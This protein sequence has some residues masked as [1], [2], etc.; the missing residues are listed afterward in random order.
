MIDGI[1]LFKKIIEYQ[2]RQYWLIMAIT[3]IYNDF[4]RIFRL[5]HVRQ[6]V[7]PSTRILPLAVNS[8]SIEEKGNVVYPTIS[9]GI[10]DID[11]MIYK[12]AISLIEFFVE[13]CWSDKFFNHSWTIINISKNSREIL[14]RFSHDQPVTQ[15]RPF[16]ESFG[17]ILKA[18]HTDGTH[19]IPQ[20]KFRKTKQKQTSLRMN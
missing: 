10:S 1:Y 12:H 11:P 18:W 4:F 19:G 14:G 13:Y 17:M 9:N 20:G 5:H 7:K 16:W 8:G 2:E 6:K 3:M 15:F